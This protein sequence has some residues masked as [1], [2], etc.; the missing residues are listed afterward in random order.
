[1]IAVLPVKLEAL[2]KRAI[3]LISEMDSI[4]QVKPLANGSI[5]FYE[6]VEHF[7]SNQGRPSFRLKG[8]DAQS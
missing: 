5:N 7:E 2:K 1:M 4:I 6:E 8:F 3:D